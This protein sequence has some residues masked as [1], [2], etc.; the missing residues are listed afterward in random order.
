MCRYP[1]C[2]A[3][4]TTCRT[5]PGAA[6]PARGK[7]D[8]SV[9]SPC[10]SWML[11]S[12]AGAAHKDS[13]V[14]SAPL[15]AP[16]PLPRPCPVAHMCRGPRPGCGCRRAAGRRAHPPARRV[17][18]V[19]LGWLRG[20]PPAR[21]LLPTP[22][23]RHRRRP[24]PRARQSSAPGTPHCSARPPHTWRSRGRAEGAPG[25]LGGGDRGTSDGRGA[26]GA[27]Q[28]GPGCTAGCPCAGT[29]RRSQ[30]SGGWAE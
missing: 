30:P 24:P 13:G 17:P 9:R 8:S 26:P 14:R 15:P 27:L 7:A 22:R 16:L 6:F 12:G 19:P 25:L 1:A 10:T 2:S 29:R 18:A 3:T 21:G 20:G 5:S 23:R 11:R 28:E 4:C